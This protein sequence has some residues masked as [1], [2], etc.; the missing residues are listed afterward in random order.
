MVDTTAVLSG[1]SFAGVVLGLILRWRFAI[2]PMIQFI[3]AFIKTPFQRQREIIGTIAT[4]PNQ[5]TECI[6][7]VIGDFRL[8]RQPSISNFRRIPST[9]NVTDLHLSYSEPEMSIPSITNAVVQSL[10]TSWAGK[11]IS[12]LSVYSMLHQAK[13]ITE[14]LLVEVLKSKTADPTTVE[15]VCVDAVTK[16][17]GQYR[18]VIDNYISHEAVNIIIE[19]LPLLIREVFETVEFIDAK[20]MPSCFSSDAVSPPTS[21]TASLVALHPIMCPDCAQGATTVT[22]SLNIAPVIV[23]P[24]RIN[25]VLSN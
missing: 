23:S 14:K 19:C 17:L 18:S 9:N 8:R 13:P 25:K 6:E 3:V 4:E 10:V 11:A 15:Q 21:K 22:E 5:N 7:V 24:T 12:L 20:C 2:V 1:L 16:I